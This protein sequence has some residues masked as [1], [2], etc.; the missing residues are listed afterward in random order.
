MKRSLTRKWIIIFGGILLVGS[1]VLTSCS[2][3]GTTK[4]TARKP[5]KKT[6]GE[7]T[8]ETTDEPT[9]ETSSE[10][11]KETNSETTKESSMDPENKKVLRFSSFDGGGFSYTV[12][13]DDP[14]IVTYDAY[15]DYGGQDPEEVDGAS[16]DYTVELIPLSSGTTKLTVKGE[17]PIMEPEIYY[18]QLTVGDDLDLQVTMV[19]SPDQEITDDSPEET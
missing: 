17:S 10:T 5:T 3:S 11:T 1:M 19:E 6:S 4:K 14:S 2:G 18:Y 12:T 13:I 8:E 9:E 7:S 15:K 16:F